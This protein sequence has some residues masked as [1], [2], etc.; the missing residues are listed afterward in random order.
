[1]ST[2]FTARRQDPG[3]AP[4]TARWLPLGAVPTDSLIRQ[5]IC[6]LFSLLPVTSRILFLEMGTTVFLQSL[7]GSSPRLHPSLFRGLLRLA[8]PIWVEI[9]SSPRRSAIPACRA[10]ARDGC[11]SSRITAPRGYHASLACWGLAGRDVV[12]QD[13]PV[14]LT[15]CTAWAQVR[16]G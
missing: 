5:F 7:S 16:P 2:R 11:S 10:P 15:L 14:Q 12:P 4:L 9:A 6:S 1:M 3:S 8:A 13:G